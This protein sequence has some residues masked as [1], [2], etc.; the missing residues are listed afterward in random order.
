MDRDAIISRIRDLGGAIRAKGATGLFIYG[1]RSRNDFRPDSDL[2]VFVDYDPTTDFSIIEL[3][4]IQRVLADSL[5]LDVHVTTREGLS[6]HFRTT[7]E[8]QAVR[9]L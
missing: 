8:D 9:V 2:D 3:S 6:P 7:V 4:G 5:G 1:S